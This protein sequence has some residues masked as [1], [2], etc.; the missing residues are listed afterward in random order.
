MKLHIWGGEIISAPY[1]LV[2]KRLKP[3]ALGHYAV[4]AAAGA[5]QDPVGSVLLS[6]CG[7]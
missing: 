7:S 4:L 5:I 1:R 6:Y 3:K 2:I